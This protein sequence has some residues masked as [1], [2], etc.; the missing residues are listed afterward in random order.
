MDAYSNYNQIP[1]HLIDEEKMAFITPMANY[2][3]NVMSLEL[4]NVGSTYQYLMNKICGELV[5][6]SVQ[7][8][9]RAG[10]DQT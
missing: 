4:K 9:G 3:Y 2:C 1:M 10:L 7:R 6:M 5:A 8:T